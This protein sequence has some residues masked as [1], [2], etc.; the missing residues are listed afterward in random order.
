VNG[1]AFNLK[2]NLRS[3]LIALFVAGFGAGFGTS[4]QNA[5]LFK[6]PGFGTSS[7][8]LNPSANFQLQKPPAGAKRGK[9]LD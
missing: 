9:L 6:P 8:Q 3:N 7:F 1:A 5:S 4:A 2:S